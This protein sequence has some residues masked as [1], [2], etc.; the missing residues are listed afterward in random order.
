MIFA[1]M[2]DEKDNVAVVTSEVKKGDSLTY[3]Y[4]GEEKEI[5]AITDIPIFH[6]IALYDI[7]CGE[8]VVKYG[9]HIGEAGADIA[10]GS[11]VHVHNVRSV[12]ENLRN[13]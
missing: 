6:K 1:L 8:K 11:W 4:R 12:R 2:I 9:E 13:A 5:T 10:A 3:K 7:A